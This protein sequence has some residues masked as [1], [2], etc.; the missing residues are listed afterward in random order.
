MK[1]LIIDE[2]N[3]FRTEVRAQARAAGQVR[4]QDRY[5]SCCRFHPLAQWTDAPT[6]SLPIPSRE[7]II[8]SPMQEHGPFHG[9]TSGY[10]APN[11]LPPSPTMDDPSGELERELAGT[12]LARG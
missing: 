9:T 1:K 3:S 5:V 6:Y 7:E 8:N 2:V 4:R 10:T 12:H 11:A